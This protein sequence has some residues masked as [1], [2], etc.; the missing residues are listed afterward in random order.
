LSVASHPKPLPRDSEE[1][2]VIQVDM[3]D[4]RR[5]AFMRTTQVPRCSIPGWPAALAE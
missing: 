5:D 2:R 4:P 1:R 3:R